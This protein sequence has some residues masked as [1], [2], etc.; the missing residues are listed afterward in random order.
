MKNLYKN[1]EKGKISGV[2]AGISEIL[3]ADVTLIRVITFLLCWFYGTGL[4]I[5]I[6]LACLLPDKDELD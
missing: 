1:S 2:C 4:L 5:Y 3:N 6:L